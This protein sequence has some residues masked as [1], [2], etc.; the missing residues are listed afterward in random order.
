MTARIIPESDKNYHLK[1]SRLQAADALGA[2]ISQGDRL[3]TDLD[4]I[5]STTTYTNAF[6]RYSTWHEFCEELL[7]R[8]FSTT[9]LRNG[10]G[11]N[12][13][14]I[15]FRDKSLP[16][17][18]S[19]LRQTVENC[20]RYLRS[21]VDRLPLI[22]SPNDDAASTPSPTPIPLDNTKVFV[23]HGHDDAAKQVVART[24]EK[25][26]LEAVILHEQA[27]KGKT[28]IE[29]LE[30]HSAPGFAVVLL[31]PDDVGGKDAKQLKP[32]ARQNVI[33]ELGLFIG[34]LGRHWVL[35]LV[36]GNIEVPTD[37]SGVV[38]EPMDTG[39]GWKLRLGQELKAAGIEVDLNKL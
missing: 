31:T 33:L 16:E 29:K 36:K 39:N 17:K 35:A 13:G 3:L 7:T 28:I 4:S 34:K 19:L 14:V 37:Y 22:D 30:E 10:F 20:T 18:S 9:L 8:M 32:R 24:I 15:S 5:N 38:Y 21:I 12:I 23:V 27:N 25:L 1:Y 11:R 2:A 26:G 6:S